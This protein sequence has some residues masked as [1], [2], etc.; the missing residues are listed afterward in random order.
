MCD[1]LCASV[2]QAHWLLTLDFPHVLS[3]P[4]TQAVQR[5]S[6]NKN[7]GLISLFPLILFSPFKAFS[8]SPLA[9]FNSP[10]HLSSDSASVYLDPATMLLPP[11]LI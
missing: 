5:L 11:I 2:L 3:L 7:A 9:S 4:V 6:A 8:I 1:L 10:L